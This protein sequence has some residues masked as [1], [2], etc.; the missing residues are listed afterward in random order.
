MRV[1]LALRG[2]VFVRRPVEPPNAHRAILR[3]SGP[4]WAASLCVA[5][6]CQQVCARSRI[7]C[8]ARAR[9]KRDILDSPVCPALS[10]VGAKILAILSSLEVPTGSEVAFVP[11][12][13]CRTA[14]S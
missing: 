6:R 7:I 2:D 9:M 14:A 5:S 10:H 1:A 4:L 8:L 13:F 3:V 11:P 12:Y